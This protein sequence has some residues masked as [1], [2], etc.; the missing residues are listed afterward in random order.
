ML[1][2]S[3]VELLGGGETATKVH[4]GIAPRVTLGR[5]VAGHDT[6]P[7]RSVGTLQGQRPDG[8]P[9][10]RGYLRGIRIV[11]LS[12]DGGRGGG[13]KLTSLAEI[14]FGGEG[15][16]VE[17][18][19]EPDFWT[20]SLEQ[21]EPSCRVDRVEHLGSAGVCNLHH[22]VRLDLAT[23]QSELPDQA[24]VC[25]LHLIGSGRHDRNDAERHIVDSS[26]RVGIGQ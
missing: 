18:V 6:R 21:A 3:F 23:E 19:T 25:R 10:E 12:L 7:H 4:R 22:Q 8:V 20:T 5:V 17:I 15:L 26:T 24:S 16:P 14:E 2:A 11:Q 1:R 13:M 9:S